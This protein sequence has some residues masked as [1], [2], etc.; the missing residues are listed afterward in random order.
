MPHWAR[1]PRWRRPARC[2]RWPTDTKMEDVPA[3]LDTV[4]ERVLLSMQA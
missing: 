2:S 4:R 3:F 1:T